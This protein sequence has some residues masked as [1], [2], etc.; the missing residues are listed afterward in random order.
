MPFTSYSRSESSDAGTIPAHRQA[1]DPTV[2]PVDLSSDGKI[3]NHGNS[4]AAS[5]ALDDGAD[6]YVSTD[7]TSIVTALATPDVDLR[8]RSST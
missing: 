8:K 6:S 3:D 7:L 1:H 5:A 4:T 2:D